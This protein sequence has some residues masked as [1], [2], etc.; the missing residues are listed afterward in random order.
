MHFR[1]VTTILHTRLQ[2]SWGK[3]LQISNC[4]THLDSWQPILDLLSFLWPQGADIKL[5]QQARDV[6]FH[7][8]V[9]FLIVESFWAVTANILQDRFT[10]GMSSDVTSDIIYLLHEEAD[11][12]QHAVTT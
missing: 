6:I 8:A 11:G 3:Y 7:Y 4:P 5:F 1:N 2:S 10:A 9:R 12:D